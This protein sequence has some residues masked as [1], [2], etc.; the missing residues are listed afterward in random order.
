MRF[1]SRDVAANDPGEQ[2]GSGRLLA[3]VLMT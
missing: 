3:I 2:L 1:V